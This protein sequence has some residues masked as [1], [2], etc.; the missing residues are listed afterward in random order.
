MFKMYAEPYQLRVHI[1]QIYIE[2]NNNNNPDSLWNGP[3]TNSVN[4]LLER[5]SHF[6][7]C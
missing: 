6:N 1:I 3:T 5:D 7:N 4:I 2:Y